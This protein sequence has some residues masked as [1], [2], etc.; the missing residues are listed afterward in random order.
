MPSANSWAVRTADGL[1]ESTC[2]FSGSGAGS[3]VGSGSGVGSSDGS[4]SG[5]GGLLGGARL[6]LRLDVRRDAHA[7]GTGVVGV[8]AWVVHPHVDRL[9]PVRP[10]DERVDVV[11]GAGGAALRGLA[12]H[13]GEPGHQAVV[14]EGPEHDVEPVLAVLPLEPAVPARA[15][16]A[17]ALRVGGDAAAVGPGA[18]HGHQVVLAAGQLSGAG[19]AGLRPGRDGPRHGAAASPE[20]GDPDRERARVVRV[21]VGVPHR[22]RH[23]AVAVGLVD[24]A[25]GVPA[26]V[27]VPVVVGLGVQVVPVDV[28]VEVVGVPLVGAQRAGA[29]P[30]GAGGG[31]AL[32]VGTR[33]RAPVVTVGSGHLDEVAV[34]LRQRAPGERAGPAVGADRDP[35]VHERGSG[36]QRPGSPGLGDGAGLLRPGVRLR[37][38]VVLARAGAPRLRLGRPGRLR[39]VARALREAPRAPERGL[40]ACPGPAQREVHVVGVRV[41]A[42]VPAPAGRGGVRAPDPPVPD[43]VLDAQAA[44]HRVAVAV[45]VGLEQPP[46]QRLHRTAVLG[47]A[48]ADAPVEG[49]PLLVL[50]GP[51]DRAGARDAQAA[52]ALVGAQQH[53][54]ER[55]GARLGARRAD[56]LADVRRQGLDLRGVAVRGPRHLRAG[57]PGADREAGD[58]GARD[59][60]G[61]NTDEKSTDVGHA[62]SSSHAGD[63]RARG[64]GRRASDSSQPDAVPPMMSVDLPIRAISVKTR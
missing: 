60:G 58:Q 6:R 36:G 50:R 37:V 62:R 34:P 17:R 43:H 48:H 21:A 40:L 47:A 28:Q 35:L 24:P 33:G 5:V 49:P 64:P 18:A 1:R 31:A 19:D 53:G 16:G 38:R 3:S 46:E 2:R 9:G 52:R 12:A 7:Q 25:V 41:R 20:V 15:R 27:A 57:R 30:A 39:P 11:L 59:G 10:P 51:A 56:R 32:G 63:V 44:G 55:G 29:L 23:A 22:Q 8:A 4:G 14:A 42:G 26:G 13:V 61:E 54:R 45:P